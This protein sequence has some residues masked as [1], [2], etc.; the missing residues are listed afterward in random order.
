MHHSK[1]LIRGVFHALAALVI[2]V[3]PVPFAFGEIQVLSTGVGLEQRQPDLSY[4]TKFIFSERGSG[5]LLANIHIVV[6]TEQGKKKVLE[7]LSA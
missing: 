4:S 3:F 5:A 6:S 1:R 2:M 7:M